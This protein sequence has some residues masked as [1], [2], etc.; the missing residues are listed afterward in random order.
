MNQ[1]EINHFETDRG[2]QIFQLPL[3][4]FPGFWAYSYL[5]LVEDL[6][7]LIDTGSGYHESNNHLEFGLQKVGDII[8]DQIR[9]IDLTHVMLTHGHIDHFGGL[10]H[11]KP[12]T[13]ALIAVHELDLRNITNYEERVSV[14]TH[15]LNSY[16]IEAGVSEEKR[17]ELLNLY[18]INKG[19]FHSVPIDFTY[20]ENG[21]QLGPFQFLHVPGHCPG[22]TVIKLHN[23]LFSG[24]HILSKTTPHMAPESI[25]LNTG[26]GHYLDSLSKLETWIDGITLTLAGHEDPVLD[27]SGRINAICDHHRMRLDRILGILREPQTILDVSRALFNEPNGYSALLAIEEAGA[28]VEY[29][30]QRGMICIENI[31]ALEHNDGPVPVRY[32]CQ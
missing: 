4:V 1:Y 24:D 30:Y 14:V 31:E 10:A 13:D 23:I 28:H 27:I 11:I 2:A 7:V 26:L 5:I 16:F 8:G 29:L 18:K 19:L 21:M 32:V 20:E 6:R 3:E 9:W 17:S 22:Q 15:R 12:R 25:T